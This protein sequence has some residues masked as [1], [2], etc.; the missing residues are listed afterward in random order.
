MLSESVTY[1]TIS[2]WEAYLG[3]SAFVASYMNCNLKYPERKFLLRA[4]LLMQRLIKGMFVSVICL[5]C[6]MKTCSIHDAFGEE[7]RIT[8]KNLITVDESDEISLGSLT[9]AERQ[10][11]RTR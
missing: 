7:I 10:F 4:A 1:E 11:Q 8:S 6:T 3:P 5:T 9:V 2:S